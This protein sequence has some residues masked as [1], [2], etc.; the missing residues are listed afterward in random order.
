M[1]DDDDAPDEPLPIVLPISQFP[2]ILHSPS[3][4]ERLDFLWFAWGEG[5]GVVSAIVGACL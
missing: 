1:H 2:T 5:E 4:F 3:R